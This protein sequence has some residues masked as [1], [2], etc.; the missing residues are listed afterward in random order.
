MEDR[1]K[2]N[3]LKMADMGRDKIL[4]VLGVVLRKSRKHSSHKRREQLKMTNVLLL[5]SLVSTIFF[6]GWSF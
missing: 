2:E 3:M 6:V 1:T 5:P 4:H